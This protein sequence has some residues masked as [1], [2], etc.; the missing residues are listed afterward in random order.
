MNAA[1]ADP[2]RL[3]DGVVGAAL[4]Q[5]EHARRGMTSWQDAHRAI[6]TVIAAGPN[7]AVG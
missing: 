2:H 3:G 1:A 5:V 6:G 4:V 7:R